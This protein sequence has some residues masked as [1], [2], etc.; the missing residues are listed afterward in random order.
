MDSVSPKETK[1][2]NELLLQ[3]PAIFIVFVAWPFCG[4]TKQYVTGFN[5]ITT[6]ADPS[7]LWSKEMKHRGTA[8]KHRNPIMQLVLSVTAGLNCGYYLITKL[9]R[10]GKKTALVNS[11]TGKTEV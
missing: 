6:C 4:R 11:T 8:L 7:S 9:E 2:G 1:E 3:S 5:S 10:G